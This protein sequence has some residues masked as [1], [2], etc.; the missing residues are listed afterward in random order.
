MA[1]DLNMVALIGRLTKDIELQ[2]TQSG[3]SVCKFQLANNRMKADQNGVDCD[4][5]SCVAW[6]NCAEVLA[7]YTHKG[8]KICAQ[9]EIRTR[10]WDAQDGSR[11]Y[12]TDVNVFSVQLL[13]PNPNAQ[14]GQ[15][16]QPNY[17]QQPQQ[18]YGGYN[19]PNGGYQQQGY[20]Q[21]PQQNNGQQQF[22]N[23]EF[24]IQ[25]DDLPF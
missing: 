17:G 19:A 8:S 7:Q 9:G 1:K 2:K 12:A 22:G 10:Q 6:N 21:Q 25:N 23:Q 13:D 5:I 11:R 4:F 14:N 24:E 18:N 3:K 15:Q 16:A 20:G